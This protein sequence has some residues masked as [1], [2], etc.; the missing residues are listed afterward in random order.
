MDTVKKICVAGVGA[1][2]TL[3]AAMLG[4]KYSSGLTLIAR[5]KRAAA[6]QEKGLVLHSQV[7]GE[8][9]SRP[10]LVTENAESIGVQDIIFLCVKN[11]SLNQMAQILRPAVGSH[12]VLI[13]V[14]NGV[15]S[16]D[17]LRELFPEAIVCDAVIYTITIS[18]P[19]FSA[20]QTGTYTHLFVGSKKQDERSQTGAKVAFQLLQAVGFQSRWAE[21][22]ESEIWQKF[23]HNCAYNS[24]TARHLATTEMIRS[25]EHLRNDL[26]EMLTEG[27]QVGIAEG[28]CL[29]PDFVA[30]KYNFVMK[31]QPP[32]ATSSM[33]H[34]MEAH[35]SLEI[36]AFSGAVIRK[37][38]AHGVETPVSKRYHRE[39]LALCCPHEIG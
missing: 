26:L 15:E 12:T 21:D 4:K 29:P 31:T 36:D 3:L 33:K 24:I 35:R 8:V 5:G 13:P 10:K 11:Y 30:Q 38:E 18:N 37:A 25:N 9:S 20:T 23:I 14:M 7:Y 34:D 19:D 17:R 2:G 1:I 28:I 16:G 39:L 22:I 6:L 32:Q 27:Y